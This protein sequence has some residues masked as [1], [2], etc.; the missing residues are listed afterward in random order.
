[1]RV[2]FAEGLAG[3]RDETGV[4]GNSLFLPKTYDQMIH[5]VALQNLPADVCCGQ[6]G[7]SG[8]DGEGI[9]NF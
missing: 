2:T 9:R 3:R 8:N 1:M 5:D 7:I 4:C 6:S